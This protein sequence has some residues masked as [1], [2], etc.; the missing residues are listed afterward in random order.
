MAR[1]PLVVRS[2]LYGILEVAVEK[3]LWGIRRDIQSTE[4]SFR[5]QVNNGDLTVDEFK[6]NRTLREM[7][8][9]LGTLPQFLKKAKQLL[10]EEFPYVDGY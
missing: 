5:S 8:G 10:E 2:H 3:E 1:L 7:R 6:T 9:W 4:E